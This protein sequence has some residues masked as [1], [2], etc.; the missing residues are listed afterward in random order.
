MS[1][2]IW[3]NEA[4][5]L[6]GIS[7]VIYAHNQHV[8]WWDNP[9]EDGTILA[10]IHSEISEALEGNRKN[11]MDDHLPQYKMEAVELADAVIRILDFCGYKNYDIGKILKEKFDYNKTRA[12]HQRENRS[13][14][15]GKR[16]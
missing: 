6:T 13:K 8:G 9:R 3:S 10:L 4:E 1:L 12:D 5:V 2:E 16:Y 14:E 7:K 11:L 15:G